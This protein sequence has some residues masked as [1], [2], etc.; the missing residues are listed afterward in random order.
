MT[1]NRISVFTN[2]RVTRYVVYMVV[3]MMEVPMVLLLLV[4]KMPMV[5]LL[6]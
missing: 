1:A 6:L 2:N 4:I 3:V 5:L